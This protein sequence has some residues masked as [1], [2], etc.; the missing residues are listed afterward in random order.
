ME[1]LKDISADQP[2]SL[3]M[4]EDRIVWWSRGFIGAE[5]TR[6]TMALLI[7]GERELEISTEQSG[8]LRTRAV[9][10]GPNVARSLGA[11]APARSHDGAC[12]TCG[13]DGSGLVVDR[14]YCPACRWLRDKV[15]AGREWLDVSDQLDAQSIADASP[16]GATDCSAIHRASDRLLAR[17]FPGVES[18]SAIDP[19]V[20][21]AAAWLRRVVPARADMRRLGAE[22]KL[23]PGRLTHL[24]TQELGVSIRTYLLWVKMCKAIELL[25]RNQSVADVA[26]AIG[27]ADSA[28][29][30]R[31]L[32]TYYSAAPS[33]IANRALVSV[34]VCSAS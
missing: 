20:Q 33:F 28:H 4:Y 15:L 26:A 27:F 7:G 22:C 11:A 21:Q 12:Q 19:R 9:L 25:A 34:R 18:A 29:L 6:P 17:F 1:P 3:F 32:R 30:C 2:A 31:V 5:T 13:G 16:A 24:F 23:S 8:S 10:V 14:V